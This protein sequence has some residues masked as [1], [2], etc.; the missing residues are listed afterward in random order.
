MSIEEAMIM[1]AQSRMVAGHIAAF[2][3]KEVSR[4]CQTGIAARPV[5]LEPPYQSLTADASFEDPVEPV[6]EELPRP[7]VT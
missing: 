7:D 6:F 1:R 5:A 3:Q 2:L 4:V